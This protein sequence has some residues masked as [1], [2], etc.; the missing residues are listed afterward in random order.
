MGVRFTRT[1]TGAFD[2]LGSISG[3]VIDTLEK[4]LTEAGEAGKGEAQGVVESSGTNREW[5]G[6]FKD[7]NGN[8]RT[9]S[10]E[11]RVDT[12]DMLNALD[13]RLI[14][15]KDIGLD[16]GWTD[17]SLWQA[18]FAAQDEGFDAPGYRY[19]YQYVPGMHV[20]SHLAVYM[21]GKVD[22]ALDAALE[23]IVNGL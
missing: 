23:E 9:S 10:G 18:Y 4:Y 22:E 16:V 5:S 12:K 13:Y 1:R 6:P 19:D 15:G 21:R 8:I 20:V 11:G 17:P 14:R 2:N 3:F 7:R